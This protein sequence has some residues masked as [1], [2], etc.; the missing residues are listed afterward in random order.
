MAVG[1]SQVW[2]WAA[3]GCARRSF[4]VRFL[5]V[6]KALLI[7]NWKLEVEVEVEADAG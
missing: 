3:S 1:D 2:S 4:F 7:I 5:Y 6:S